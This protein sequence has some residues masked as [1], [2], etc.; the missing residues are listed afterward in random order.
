MLSFACEKRDEVVVYCALDQVFSEPLLRQFEKETGIRVKS[1]FD[2][3]ANKTVGLV[4]TLIEEKEHPRCDVFWNNELAQTIKLRKA[5]VLQPYVSPMSKEIPEQFKDAQ[6]YWTG[7]AAR[8]RIFIVNQKLLSQPYPSSIRDFTKPEWKGKFTLAKPL[9][10]T[11]ITHFSALFSVW[12][13]EAMQQFCKDM[14]ANAPNLAQGNAHVSKLVASGEIPFG[15][16]DTDDFRVRLEEGAPV[17]AVYPDAEAEGTLLIPNSISLVANAPHPEL[18]KKL[19]DW[20]LRPE[21]EKHLAFAP[22]AQIPL[23]PGVEHPPYVK[24]PGDFKAMKVDW[25]K[26]AEELERRA[27]F[28][29]ENFAR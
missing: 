1:V 17:E 23:R 9:T 21:I 29:R 7:F 26:V 18:G 15:L 6:G 16:T 3:E 5:G 27:P 19:I 24:V 8:A 25:E 13:E 14:L 4:R 10:G 2:I 11:T 28:F 20:V 22:S 12:G